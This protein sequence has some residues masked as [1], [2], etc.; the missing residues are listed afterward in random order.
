MGPDSRQVELFVTVARHLSF[1]RAAA[2][3]NTPQPW[4]SA[5][6]RRLEEQLGFELFRRTS[7]RVELTA[8]GAALLDSA[9]AALDA[10]GALRSEIAALKRGLA[11]TLKIGAAPYS[12]LFPRRVRALEDFAAAHPN[13]VIEL[14]NDWSPTLREQVLTGELDVAFSIGEGAEAGLE[15]RFVEAHAPRLFLRADDPLSE[16]DAVPIE[17]LCDRTVITF[18]RATNPGLHDALYGELASHGARL[19]RVPETG[20]EVF[21]RHILR[22]GSVAIAFAGPLPPGAEGKIAVRRLAPEPDPF[23]LFLVR[24]SGAKSALVRSFWNAVLPGDAART[25][26]AA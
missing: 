2:E 11:G 7:R 21:V 19:E 6:I 10:L 26:A 18:P 24:R 15:S 9:R 12:K 23:Q 8:Q 17:R 4:L 3:L 13:V 20:I 1:S 16:L 14:E 25:I 5:Q 22:T